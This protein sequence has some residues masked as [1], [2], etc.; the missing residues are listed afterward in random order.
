MQGSRAPRRKI[1][2]SRAPLLPSRAPF[3]QKEHFCSGSKSREALSSRLHNKTFRAPGLQRPP[4]WAPSYWRSIVVA[5]VSK[6]KK[7]TNS[8]CNN[9][10]VL[11]FSL[12][13]LTDYFL[14]TRT[15]I[16]AKKF[17]LEIREHWVMVLLPWNETLLQSSFFFQLPSP[18]KTKS[19]KINQHLNFSAHAIISATRCARQTTSVNLNLLSKHPFTSCCYPQDKI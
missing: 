16:T 1:R 13:G 8:L 12:T 4:L 10:N 2:G 9:H 11:C 18:S 19:L 15:T 3:S 17:L 5:D 6:A 14:V 7:E